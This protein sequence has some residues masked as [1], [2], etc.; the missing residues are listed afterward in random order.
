[1]CFFD[2]SQ[3]LAEW[4]C[5][6]QERVGSFL[7]VIGREQVDWATVPAIMML[8]HEDVELFQKIQQICESLETKRFQ[9][10]N[11]LSINFSDMNQASMMNSVHNGVP[12]SNCGYGSKILRITAM[13]LEKAVVW[14]GKH[15][16]TNLPYLII[17]C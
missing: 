3:V 10:E 11:M 9:Q 13:M 6:V 15:L 1:M 12:L 4:A 14:P 17:W 7:G 2:C 16:Q 8:E 5:T